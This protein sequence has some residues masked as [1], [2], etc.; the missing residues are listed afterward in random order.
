MK[1]FPLFAKLRDKRCLLVGGGVVASRKLDLLCECDAKV[2]VISPKLCNALQSRVDD[3]DYRC[4]TFTD[5]DLQGYHLVIAA[6]DDHQLNTQIG[7]TCDAAGIWVNVVSGPEQGNIIIPATLERGDLRIAIST[8]GRSPILARLLKARL[9]ML[10]PQSYGNLMELIDHYR[11][12]V[13]ATFVQARLRRRFWENILQGSVADMVLSGRTSQAMQKIDNML[14][15]AQ[16]ESVTGEVYLVGAGP[17]DPDLLTF[18]AMRLIQQADIVVHDRLVSDDI[19]KMMRRGVEKIYVGK[20]RANH[21]LPQQDI[22]ALLVKLAKE[23]K[24]VLRIKGGD[25]F[26]FGRG[27]EELETLISHGIPFQIVPGI[28]AALGCASY[29]GIPLTHRDFSQACIFVA[30]YLK[31]GKVD[32]NWPMLAHQ[33]Q[34]LVFYMGLY[35]LQI[36]CEQLIAHGMPAQTP[37]ALISNGT[38]QWQ[39]VK[40]GKLNTLPDIVAQCDNIQPPTLIIVGEVVSL[41]EK[42]RW[43]EAHQSTDESMTSTTSQ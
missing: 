20:R 29:A 8:T 16:T 33:N 4:K 15:N 31:N 34:T 27:G 10:I 14:R 23:G 28:T 35:G 26:V 18:R 7:H 42:L 22:N 5:A 38:S 13:K 36:I 9:N 37:A 32:L 19:L 30:G 41:H 2:V 11:D 3:F 40:I 24:R 39:Q 1:Y 21:Y 43:F 12:Q 6:T 25:P 17:G